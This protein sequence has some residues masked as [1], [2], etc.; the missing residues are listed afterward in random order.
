[1]RALAEDLF[2]RTE[3]HL[4]ATAVIHL[5]ERLKL[6]HRMAALETLAVEGLAARH[7]HFKSLCQCIHYRHAHAMQA[8]GCLI[9]AGIEF[10]ARMKRRHDHFERRFLREFGMGINR[11]AATIVADRQPSAF[12]DVHLDPAR[13]TGHSLVHGVVDHFGKQMME[14]RF[15]SAADIHARTTTNGLKPL[16]NLNRS[17]GIAAFTGRP[18]TS[19]GRGF[20]G[21]GR[22]GFAS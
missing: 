22:C 15:V 17:S 2:I 16:Q 11:D 5:A 4:G 8:A 3:T 10:A 21:L 19:L 18:P 6:G 1:M 14:R 7:F 20:L 13:M 12:L 9:G